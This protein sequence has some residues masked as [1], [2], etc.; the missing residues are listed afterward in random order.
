MHSI[1]AI[2]SFN[3]CFVSYS[4]Y[5]IYIFLYALPRYYSTWSEISVYQN[6]SHSMKKQTKRPVRPGK[7]QIS[8][9]IRPVAVRSTGSFR[10]KVHTDIPAYGLQVINL[11][12]RA[13]VVVP[14]GGPKKSPRTFI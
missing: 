1:F 11:P 2:F 4:F 8:L 10:P 12:V 13:L 6:V 14:C 9:C 5:D 3:I 7:T